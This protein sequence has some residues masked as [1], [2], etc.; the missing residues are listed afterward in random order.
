M[1]LGKSITTNKGITVLVVLVLFASASV[2]TSVEEF[3]APTYAEDNPYQGA[4]DDTTD[5]KDWRPLGDD[6]KGVKKGA[7]NFFGKIMSNKMD[8]RM[9]DR[10]AHLEERISIGQ[11]IIIA[12][13][14]C[15]DSTDC[16]VDSNELEEMI[17]N[18]NFRHS[19]MQIKLNL[20]NDE[21][22]EKNIAKFSDDEDRSQESCEEDGG[23]WSDDRQ[24]CYYEDERA[25]SE[26]DSEDW[27]D[28]R[29]EE[30]WSDDKQEWCDAFLD[31]DDWGMW[32][33]D[34]K[35]AFSDDRAI[36]LEAGRIAISFCISSDDCTADKEVLR[37]VTEHMSL[38]HDS[39]RDCTETDRCARS[40]EDPRGI[41]HRL[42]DV[43]RR[44][45]NA[46]ETRPPHMEIS[47]DACNERG[48]EWIDVEDRD[49]EFSFCNFW[50]DDDRQENNWETTQEECEEEGGSWSE[51]RNECYEEERTGDS[52]S[53]ESR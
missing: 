40:D 17:D 50:F 52:N 22:S 53:E 46:E 12:Y 42:R 43:I 14:F 36:M 29:T 28:C 2:G 7:K 8:D 49:E 4:V 25:D 45:P 10:E 3:A 32:D 23:T 37:G 26:E 39:H 35:K 18:L 16:E 9:E 38:R 24:V 6:S 44:T 30:I 33:I 15:I 41:F 13:Q 47:E 21:L 5:D 31:K 20:D 34:R 27:Y 1:K 48:G 19:D 11:E 51:E